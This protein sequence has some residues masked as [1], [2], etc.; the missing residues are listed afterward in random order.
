MDNSLSSKSEDDAELFQNV[1]G[2]SSCPADRFCL[3]TNE[4]FNEKE[5]GDMLAI[6]GNV[7]L[8]AE[9]LRQFGFSVGQHD[10][11]SSVVNKLSTVGALVKGTGLDGD[12]FKIDA[13]STVPR[14]ADD[15]N[16]AANSV[17]TQEVTRI[18][19]SVS[20]DDAEMFI[21]SSTE[22]TLT[23]SNASPGECP[24][25]AQITP[26]PGYVNTG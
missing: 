5:L 11:V 13:S 12:F 8:N 7:Q 2:V 24:L 1:S 6:R 25:L 16:D 17:V 14:L 21:N 26:E 20:I 4:L 15:W 18:S 9:Q 23:I 10:G 19:M 22:T 3:Y